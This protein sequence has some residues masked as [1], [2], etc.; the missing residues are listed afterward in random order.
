MWE[1]SLWGMWVSGC[2]GNLTLLHAPW[3]KEIGKELT[4]L[5]IDSLLSLTDSTSFNLWK[6]KLWKKYYF[7]PLRMR[8]WSLRK[9]KCLSWGHRFCIQQSQNLDPAVSASKAHAFPTVQKNH[10]LYGYCS[11][12][13]RLVCRVVAI[14]S[15]IIIFWGGTKDYA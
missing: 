13:R 14:L 11:L 9:N 8:K 7:S 4:W 5:N 15:K 1:R 10:Y 12:K 2:S 3:A 6:K